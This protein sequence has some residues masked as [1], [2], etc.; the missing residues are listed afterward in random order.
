VIM[1]IITSKLRTL[2]SVYGSFQLDRFHI[3]V[4][5]QQADQAVTPSSR[6]EPHLMQERTPAGTA[7]WVQRSWALDGQPMSLDCSGLYDVD[8][9][10]YSS[11]VVPIWL[12][13]GPQRLTHPRRALR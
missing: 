10:L 5:A 4:I 13:S 1:A 2:Y 6:G 9:R 3:F 8:T 11:G 7:V 12:N